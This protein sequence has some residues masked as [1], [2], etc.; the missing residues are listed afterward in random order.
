VGIPP[1]RKVYSFDIIKERIKADTSAIKKMEQMIEN[2]GKVTVDELYWRIP[3]PF[4]LREVDFKGGYLVDILMYGIFRVL[5]PQKLLFELDGDFFQPLAATVKKAVLEEFGDMK[6]DE[7]L[8]TQDFDVDK[9]NS[10]L[11]NLLGLQC[12]VLGRED[13]A[14]SE[15]AEAM[16]NAIQAEEIARQTAKAKRASAEG[17]RDAK[18][19]Q[20]EGEKKSRIL[21][22]EGD[23]GA[24]QVVAV[25]KAKRYEELIN[26]FSSAGMDMAEATVKATEQISLEFR[27]DAIGKIQGTFVEGGAGAG[28]NIN[29]GR[30]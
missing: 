24:I 30:K 20:A 22:G 13:F 12:E 5:D 9:L 29:T 27:A 14:I 28:I 3:R 17:D 15:S 4:L 1:F 10:S 23:A 11:E 18:I 2:D 26:L 6:W 16:Q 19:I 7:F 8:A 25:A 21:Q